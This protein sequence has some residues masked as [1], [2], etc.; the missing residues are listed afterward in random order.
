M[1]AQRRIQAKMSPA[2]VNSDTPFPSL[3]ADGFEPCRLVGSIGRVGLLVAWLLLISACGGGSSSV[4]TSD[5]G[6][7]ANSGDEGIDGSSDNT[8][9]GTSIE[10]NADRCIQPDALTEFENVTIPLGLCYESSTDDYE[11]YTVPPEDLV[12]STGGMALE[13]V[14]GDGSLELYVTR[15]GGLPGQMFT[16][17]GQFFEEELSKRGIAPSGNEHA[18]YFIDV[19]T[20]GLK[21]F[22]SIQ[23]NGLIEVFMQDAL[24][25]F[26]LG[27]VGI[28]HSRATQGLAAADFDLDGDLDLF[29]SHW[30]SRTS[31]GDLASEYL[32]VNHGGGSFEDRS[33]VFELDAPA[34]F[35]WSFTP[36]WADYN[37]DGYPDLLLASDFE[38]S[39]VFFNRGGQRLENVTTS[40][41]DDENGMGAAVGDYD[42][43][44]DL[45][46]F[47]TSI[48]MEERESDDTSIGITGNRLYV[49]SDGKGEW[50]DETDKAQVR[51]GY[52]GWGA[53]FADFDNDGY[54]DIF[55]TNGW[56]ITQST[57]ALLFM[58][59]GD[60]TFREE[61]QAKGILHFDWGR[62]VVCHDYD[63]DGLVDIFIGN[64]AL[65]PVAYRNR[66]FGDNRYL[67]VR[68]LGLGANPDAIGARVAVTTAEGTQVDEIRLGTWFISQQP[69]VLHFGLGQ[70]ESADRVEITWPDLA[71]SITIA[72]DVES[73]QLVEYQQPEL[74]SPTLHVIGGEGSGVYEPGTEVAI[75]ALDP[76]E[77][78]AFSHW[79]A[80]TDVELDD[81]RSETTTL[82][83]P[84]RS[85]SVTAHYLPGVYSADAEISEARRWNEVLLQAIRNDFARPTVHAR[86]LF[87]VSAAMYDAWAAFDDTATTWLLGRTQA[88]YS[89]DFVV[90]ME[91]SDRAAAQSEA[92]SYAAYRLI[93]HRF[94]ESPG[95]TAMLRDANTLMDLL[96]HPVTV[97][98]TE[99]DPLMPATLGNFVA[100]CYI[101][102]G[103]V[104]GSNEADSYENQHYDPVNP[105]L[106]PHEP[107]NP[108]IEDMNRWQPLTLEE[109]VDQSGNVVDSTPSF[110]GA[111]WG[112]VWPFAL[113]G[114]DLETRDR[115]GNTYS[116]YHDPGE[117]PKHGGTMDDLYKWGF[118]LVSIW[119]SHLDPDDE[120]T[121]DIS[122]ASIG[123]IEDYPEEFEDYEDFYDRLD[124]GD[125]GTGYEVNPA[126]QLPYSSQIVPRA[127]YTRVLA[128]FWADGPD[129]ET[130]PGH[131]FVILNSVTEHPD[132]LRRYQ[133]GGQELSA[134]EWDVKSYLLLG[135]AMHDSAISA[136]SNK[137]WYDYIRPI[138]AIRATADL[139]QSSDESRPS[140]SP[141]GITLE[142]GLIELVEAGDPLAGD[143]DEH[144]GKIKLYTWKGPD[145]VGDAT[146]DV[147]GVGWILAENWWPYQRPTFVTPP[148]AGYVS[149]HSTYSRAAAESLTFLIG[150]RYFP[151][152]MSSFEVKAGQFL[153]FERGPSMDL[154]LQWAT[155][156]DASDQCSLSR[157]WGGI[158]PPVDD[159]PGRLMGIKI[160][161]RATEVAHQLFEGTYEH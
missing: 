71:G 60:G 42:R 147:A 103:M 62:G 41:I 10:G 153:V 100:S 149:G 128:E 81:K 107:G 27:D 79:T 160:A 88:D 110:I 73:N 3:Q 7:S 126:T 48:W 143:D 83:M 98:S 118:T 161:D 108:D 38:T 119:G 9:D 63:D 120:V 138:S 96:E 61:A 116:V 35:E 12:I 4:D 24:G 159:I 69:P 140:Y 51:E 66:T 53:C 45:D 151:G 15:G 19:D 157:I 64:H 130:P 23:Y 131:W 18:G 155:F 2:S 37:F 156:Q 125:P 89:C 34:G 117:P 97:T 56:D 136:W 129:S 141:D 1:G 20:D 148:F 67:K 123:G 49:N 146:V 6:S 92:A 14:D 132:L 154:T 121:W 134:L 86:N 68:L 106:L 90:E 46:W 36:T 133:G 40:V 17:N 87:H 109:A 16:W 145:Y 113:E 31:T 70:H 114:K 137:G 57:P 55:H 95:R 11:N 111:E 21:D 28:E 74:T 25:Q 135:G 102:M 124:G 122:P 44:G 13:D 127:D 99:V 91:P 30:G 78:Y 8:P 58:S 77:H 43:D 47:V 39:Q 150:D 76:R 29:F 32:W 101:D 80:S 85:V 105:P 152:G 84:E 50:V 144:V 93:R 158:H 52:W 82:V 26:E 112:D 115:D 65:S 22:V 72:E 139:G 59:N 94:Q 142:E 5:G 75:T 33:H 54:I 104:D